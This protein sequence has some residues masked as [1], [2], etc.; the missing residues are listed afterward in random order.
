MAKV[1]MIFKIV[2]VAI[3]TLYSYV[4]GGVL[5][6][7]AALSALMASYSDAEKSLIEK[8]HLIVEQVCFGDAQASDKKYYIATA[9]GPGGRK[10]TILERFLQE[11][12]AQKYGRFVYL[13]PDM[14]CLKYMAHTYQANSFSAYTIAQSY[15]Y[16]VTTKNA[17]EKWRNAS[18][19]ITLK[20]LEKAYEARFS[21]VHGTT[22]TGPLAPVVVQACKDAGYRTIFLLCSGEDTFRREAIEYRNR[23]QRFYQST[24]EDAVQ[25]G[26]GFTQRMAFF[27]EQ[28]DELRLYWSTSLQERELLAA[29]FSAGSLQI[30]NQQAYESFA[31]KYAKDAALLQSK[32]QLVLPA[33]ESLI[34][35]YKKRFS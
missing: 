7:D 10:S 24:P 5:F 34:A 9:G 32:Q 31:A 33:W 15:D 16:L 3:I 4:Q 2:S 19:Y 12:D 6:D 18:N 25:K 23:E 29:V 26:L 11:P 8:D 28:G 22:S 1:S 13:D 27:F 21:I 20:L 17:Y 30:I 35:G 14:R